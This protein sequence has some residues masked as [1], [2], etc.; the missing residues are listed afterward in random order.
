MSTNVAQERSSQNGAA[1]LQVFL[2]TLIVHLKQLAGN[3]GG[4][5]A[6]ER[7]TKLTIVTKKPLQ[8]IIASS[9]TKHIYKKEKKENLS[10]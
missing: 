8:D 10:L 2:P 5:G 3:A 4:R 9:F 6:C 7:T 1:F